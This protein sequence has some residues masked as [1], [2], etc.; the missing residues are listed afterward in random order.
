MRAE[1]KLLAVMWM[2]LAS[3]F[4]ICG[5]KTKY[6]TTEKIS[7]HDVLRH[8]TLH[9]RD[10]IYIQD[11]ITTWLKGDSVF[12]DRWHR[13]TIHEYIY[14]TK[15]DTCVEVKKVDVPQIVERALT[16]WEQFRLDY[17]IWFI[18]ATCVLLIML[19]LVIYKMIKVCRKSR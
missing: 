11:S 4:C 16:T 8:D 19:A 15:I 3:I 18:A 10:S 2:V 17:A 5:C 9:A 7:Y 6:I 14:K 12:R 13:E 1:A